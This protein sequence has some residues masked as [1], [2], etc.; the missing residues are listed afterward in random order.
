MDQV[1]GVEER[2]NFDLS[3]GGM[4]QRQ[5]IIGK[6]Q[7]LEKNTRSQIQTGEI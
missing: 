6:E 5:G 7:V 1:K 4:G 2:E 3:N